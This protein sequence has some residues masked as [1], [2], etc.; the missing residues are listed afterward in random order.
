MAWMS[1]FPNT[2]IPS[3]HP[4]TNARQDWHSG[5]EER[6]SA[7]HSF[8]VADPAST[9]HSANEQIADSVSAS[10]LSLGAMTLLKEGRERERKGQDVGQSSASKKGADMAAPS[11]RR[12]RA[13]QPLQ[14]HR[15]SPTMEG[16]SPGSSCER[17][18]RKKRQSVRVER[19][20]GQGKPLAQPA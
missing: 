13:G 5:K 20:S 12:G 6:L 2:H 10:C 11:C 4:L 14:E 17:S 7:H 18:C 19:S 1:L 16:N 9:S 8:A 3:A 15:L